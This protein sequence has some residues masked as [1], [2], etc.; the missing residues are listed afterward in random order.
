MAKSKIL[1]ELVKAKNET[2]HIYFSFWVLRFLFRRPVHTC[3][4]TIVLLSR[5]LAT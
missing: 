3:T 2:F 5:L 4:C 1:L